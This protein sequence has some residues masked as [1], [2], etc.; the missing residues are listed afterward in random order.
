[1]R[2]RGGW[3]R[4]EVLVVAFLGLLAAGLVVIFLQ[5]SRTPS[6]RVE[7]AMHLERLGT[8][9][10]LYHDTHKSL[11]AS[12]IA[13]GYAT[14][15][16]QIA[17]YLP[18]DGGK[19]LQ[20]WDEHLPYHAQSAEARQAQVWVYYC[21]ARRPPG[22]LSVSGDTGPDGKHLPGALGDYGC[23]PASQGGLATWMTPEADG[24]LIVGQVLDKH[25][26]R[27]DRWKSLTDLGQLQRGEQYT[28]LFGERHVAE[29]GFGTTAWGDGSLYNGSQP[30]SFARLADAEHP[31]AASAT[32][33]YRVNFGS[34][35]PG[36]CQFLM[37]D[38][39]LRTFNTDTPATMLQALIPRRLPAQQ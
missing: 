37:A 33:P 31:L 12:C 27:I 32:E 38:K 22:Q 7:C 9:V 1:V 14:W 35:H 8:A 3:T 16:V 28:L 11:P 4:V 24:A 39:S 23:T 21:P 6:Q 34:W 15:A 26:E 10:R 18:R 30:A 19:A 17:P 25:G 5:H 29:E 20:A 2:R 13:P 36:V